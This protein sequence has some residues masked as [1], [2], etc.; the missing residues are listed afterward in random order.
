M[1]IVMDAKELESLLRENLS[2]VNTDRRGE[3]IFVRCPY[4]GDSDKQHD[5]HLAIKITP[6]ENAVWHCVRCDVGGLFNMKLLEDLKIADGEIT[7]L[8]QDNEKTAKKFGRSQSGRIRSRPANKV[9][10]NHIVNVKSAQK[11]LNYLNKRFKKQ[12]TYEQLMRYNVVFDFKTMMKENHLRLNGISQKT[13][14][15]L[16][17]EAVGFMTVNRS[18]IIFRNIENNWENRYFNYTLFN[19]TDSLKYFAYNKQIDS[20][21]NCLNVVLCEGCMDLI[22]IVETFYEDKKDDP[23]WLFMSCSGKSYKRVLSMLRN[24]GFFDL[25]LFIY[26]DNDTDVSLYRTL[27]REDPILKNKRIEVYFNKFEGEKDFG[28]SSDRS[29]RNLVVI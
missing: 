23:E 11:K 18:M 3:H 17:K 8:A 10:Y 15:I 4:C 7:R 20:L 21:C 25:N 27:K 9:F 22:G 14:N 1:R 5:A 12:F 24:K 19:N 2:V 29:D 6:D 26:A 28:V 16:H 13:L